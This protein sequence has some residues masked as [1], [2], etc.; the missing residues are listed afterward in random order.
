MFST[1]V[2]QFISYKVLRMRADSGEQEIG[3]AK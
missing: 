2:V 1:L 3:N